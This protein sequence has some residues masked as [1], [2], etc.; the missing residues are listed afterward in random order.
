MGPEGGGTGWGYGIRG[1]VCS[2]RHRMEA[3]VWRWSE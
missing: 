1:G 3:W 2:V